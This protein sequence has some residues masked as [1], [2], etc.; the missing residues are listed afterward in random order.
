MV[1]KLGEVKNDEGWSLPFSKRNHTFLPW[2][3]KPHW[4][5]N[6]SQTQEWRMCAAVCD[7]VKLQ[8]KVNTEKQWPRYLLLKVENSRYKIFRS[9]KSM[10][11]TPHK[12]FFFVVTPR[13]KHCFYVCMDIRTYT[14][15]RSHVFERT[16]RRMS[17][18]KT[19]ERVN[20]FRKE[21]ACVCVFVAIQIQPGPIVFFLRLGESTEGNVLAHPRRQAPWFHKSAHG[22][23]SKTTRQTRIQH[24]TKTKSTCR[25]RFR[26]I[27]LKKTRSRLNEGEIWRQP[28]NCTC[29]DAF[30]NLPKMK[31]SNKK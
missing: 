22:C 25:P 28:R 19:F 23:Q 27:V 24:K 26:N 6:P 31:I 15:I 1:E 18:V 11:K 21:R 4:I 3:Y 7:L 16:Y 5:Y 8:K 30:E 12:I 13:A 10:N 17:R 14:Y 20:W 9:H 2:T 29:F